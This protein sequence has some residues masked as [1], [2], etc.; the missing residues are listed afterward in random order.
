MK[1]LKIA[2]LSFAVGLVLSSPTVAV[3]AE[4][5]PNCDPTFTYKG[6]V[7]TLIGGE[8][9]AECTVCACAYNC[10]PAEDE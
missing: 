10:G 5:S 3:L 4:C 6:H 7:C 9:N 2:M 8:C 1:R